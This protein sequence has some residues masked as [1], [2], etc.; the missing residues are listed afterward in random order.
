MDTDPRTPPDDED[1]DDW[2][3]Y[4]EDFVWDD[5]APFWPE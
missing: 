4:D 5:D 1:E 2:P 3:P